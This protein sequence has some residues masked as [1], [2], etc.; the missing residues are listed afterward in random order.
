MLCSKNNLSH[1]QSDINTIFLLLPTKIVSQEK[2]E[3]I[4]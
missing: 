2:Q 3:T 1:K 4:I